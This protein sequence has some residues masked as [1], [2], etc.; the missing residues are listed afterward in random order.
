MCGLSD[1]SQLVRRGLMCDGTRSCL[2]SVETAAIAYGQTLD[3]PGII[4]PICNSSGSRTSGS[5]E[6][7][8]HCPTLYTK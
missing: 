6:Y 2:T 5:Y 4:L 3:A 7:S 1:V 8:S